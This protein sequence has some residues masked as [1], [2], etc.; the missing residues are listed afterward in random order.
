MLKINLVLL[1]GIFFLGLIA[2]LVI[3]FI[4]YIKFMNIFTEEIL[5]NQIFLYEYILEIK[6]NLSRCNDMGKLRELENENN[7][8][9]RTGLDK[10][11]INLKSSEVSGEE[12]LK[13][14]E[15]KESVFRKYVNVNSGEMFINTDI[16]I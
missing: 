16:N 3:L 1:M 13:Y 9:E 7:S 2:I 12:L 15:G 5:K 4:K 14:I 8:N 11:I 10:E 6:S